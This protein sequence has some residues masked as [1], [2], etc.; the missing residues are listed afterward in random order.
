MKVTVFGANGGVARIAVDRL[1]AEGHEVTAVVRNA[2]KMKPR[3][4]L[5]V[6]AIPDLLRPQN[7]VP[8]LEGQD[9]VLSGVGP[10]SNKDGPIA[11]TVTA[12]IITA[13]L[14]SGVKRLITVSA[15][16]V[17]DM[18]A[19]EGLLGRL[20]LYPVFRT[21]LRPVFSDLA[22][23]EADMWSSGLEATTV[24]PPRLTDGPLTRKYRQR[25]GGSVPGALIISR[26]DTADAM[27]AA[28]SNPDT[29]GQPVGV[30]M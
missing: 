25:V 14:R 27:L 10:R 20:I 2:S 26:A 4:G 30:A 28:L 22:Q 3:T 9:A 5:R 15:A 23:M 1:L 29:I 21:L 13:M 19:D 18:P 24:R 7:L 12:S 6:V 17:G 16:P 11:S 8:A